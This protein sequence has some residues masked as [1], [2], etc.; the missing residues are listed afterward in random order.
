M[1]V[2]SSESTIVGLAAIE[3]FRNVPDNRH[4]KSYLIDNYYS[5]F[6][7]PE[8][9]IAAYLAIMRSATFEDINWID[10]LWK[11]GIFDECKNY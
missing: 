1:E 11:N 9:A 7:R 2:A 6:S 5:T 4:L 10:N 3:A 8:L